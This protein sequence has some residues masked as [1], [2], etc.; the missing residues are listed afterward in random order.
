MSSYRWRYTTLKVVTEIDKKD[1]YLQK[2]LINNGQH[3]THDQANG[4]LSYMY[5][6]KAHFF[7][8]FAKGFLCIEA[9]VFILY[10]LHNLLYICYTYIITFFV[11]R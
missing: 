10:M 9:L 1:Y 8:K 7:S 11:C 5:Y 6:K 2:K 4:Y 3:R